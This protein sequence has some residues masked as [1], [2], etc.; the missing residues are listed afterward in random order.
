TDPTVT[1]DPDILLIGDYNSYAMEDPITVIQIAGFTNLIESFLGLGVYSYVFDGQ[2][3]YLDYALG[4]ASLIS[5]V[6]GVG[7]YHI[8]A[9]EP[10]VLDYN[11]EFKSA[12]QIVSLYAPDQFR[13]SDHDPVIIGLNLT[14]TVMLPLV[15]R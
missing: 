14:H 15:V 13:A 2:W 11:T 4:S 1:G 7:D 5:Q 8:N 10:S 12:G 3:G 9:D 6:N